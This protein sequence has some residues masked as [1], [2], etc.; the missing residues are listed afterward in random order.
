MF[1]C[2]FVLFACLFVCPNCLTLDCAVRRSH[3][4]P[5]PQGERE[6]APD[7]ESTSDSAP[8]GPRLCSPAIARAQPTPAHGSLVLICC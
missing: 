3:A 7:P 4:P 1:D 8:A 2:L 6:Q 5:T